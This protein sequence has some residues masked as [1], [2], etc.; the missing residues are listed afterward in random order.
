MNKGK[1]RI[2]VHLA[3]VE[4]ETVK[5]VSFSSSQIQGYSWSCLIPG[6]ELFLCFTLG[7]REW[8][9]SRYFPGIGDKHRNANTFTWP[10]LSRARP[11]LPMCRCS[12]AASWMTDF[13]VLLKAARSVTMEADG[14]GWVILGLNLDINLWVQEGCGGRAFSPFL[15]PFSHLK[16]VHYVPGQIMNQQ[17]IWISMTHSLIR[18]RCAPVCVTVKGWCLHVSVQTLF[19]SCPESL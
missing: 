18:W 10:V 11:T 15:L 7:R 5:W 13:S 19:A 2:I 8:K 16:R 1:I 9:G 6:P 14:S 12:T 3:V 4:N 17:H